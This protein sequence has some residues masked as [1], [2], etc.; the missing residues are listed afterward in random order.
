M[1]S[2]ASTSGWAWKYPGRAGDTGSIGSGNYCDDRY[3]AATCTGWG[4]L[5]IR[6]G[7]AR[8]VVAALQQGCTIEQACREVL[9]D[10]PDAGM[11][12]NDTPLHVLAVASDGT[13]GAF[14]TAANSQF[15][16]WVED[17]P[18][19]TVSDRIQIIGP[20]ERT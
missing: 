18:S 5:A 3:G 19:A 12:T 14:S 10:L 8:A 16:S 20:K 17:A 11:G 6:A 4:E 1:A 15:T 7:A 9:L 13:I 2:A